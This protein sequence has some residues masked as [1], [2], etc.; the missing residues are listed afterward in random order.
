MAGRVYFFS[1]EG[2]TTVIEPGRKFKKLAENKLDAGFLASPAVA[3][4]AFY[5]RTTAN[6]YRVEEMR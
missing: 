6:L 4:D 3:G 1:E 2:I 5:L